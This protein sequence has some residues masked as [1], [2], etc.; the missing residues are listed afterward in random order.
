MKSSIVVLKNCKITYTCN[1][2]GD[3]RVEISMY[4][5]RAIVLEGSSATFGTP[6]GDENFLSSACI[7][8]YGC[9]R[10]KLSFQKARE[11]F[12]VKPSFLE[13]NQPC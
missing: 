4:D 11:E 7:D 12:D 8:A 2:E 3:V 13:G 5:G 9:I 1:V 10:L 6:V